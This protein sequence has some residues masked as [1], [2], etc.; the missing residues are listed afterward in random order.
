V[1]EH[2][3]QDGAVYQWVCSPSMR[4]YLFSFVLLRQILRTVMKQSSIAA[5]LPR[6][7][8]GLRAAFVRLI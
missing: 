8:F 2:A 4:G 6:T 5:A 1:R 7:D 3:I